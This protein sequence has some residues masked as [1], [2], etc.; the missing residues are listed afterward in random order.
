MDVIHLNAAEVAEFA[1]A[2]E[3]AKENGRTVRVAV[4][5]DGFKASVGGG[6]WSP[7]MGSRDA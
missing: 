3:F 4:D 2:F 6:M 7:G 1:E 5:E